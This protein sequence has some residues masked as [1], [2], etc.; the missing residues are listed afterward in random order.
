MEKTSTVLMTSMVC[1]NSE[2]GIRA[3]LKPVPIP[4]SKKRIPVAYSCSASGQRALAPCRSVCVISQEFVSK[5]FPLSRVPREK[6]S[7]P[8][9]VER[10]MLSIQHCIYISQY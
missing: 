10:A 7:E 5:H 3:N 4:M 9:C 1:L 6:T 8:S 2:V